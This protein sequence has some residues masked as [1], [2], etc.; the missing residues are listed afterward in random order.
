MANAVESGEIDVAQ[1][2]VGPVEA[3]RLQ[4]VEGL[5]VQRVNAPRCAT[6]CSI[7]QYVAPAE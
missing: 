7:T 2:T 4:D 1:R 3:V 5:T 6:S